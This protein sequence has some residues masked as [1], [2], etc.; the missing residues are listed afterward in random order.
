MELQLFLKE[1]GF[2]NHVYQRSG[3]QSVCYVLTRV[4]LSNES[5]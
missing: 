1:N 4:E 2:V 5:G 3:M